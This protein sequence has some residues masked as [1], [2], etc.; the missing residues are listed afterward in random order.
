MSRID[1][2]IENAQ[3]KDGQ[4]GV[5]NVVDGD[6]HRLKKGLEESGEKQRAS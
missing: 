4:I 5:E 6:E 2:L 3:G 1:V